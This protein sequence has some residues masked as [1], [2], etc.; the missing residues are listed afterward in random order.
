VCSGPVLQLDDTPVMCQAGRGEPSFRAYLW[1][2]VHP[3]V[4]AV[5]HRFPAGRASRLLADELAGFAGTIVGD[6][7][8]GNPAAA[9][10]LGP[11]IP[12]GACWAHVTRKLRDAED[13]APSTAT[14]FPED[15]RQLFAVDREATAARLAPAGR[16]RPR[17]ETSRPILGT[18]L[19]R[20]RRVRGQFPDAGLF[21][22]A[23]KMAR[24][25]QYVRNRWRA[26]RQFLCHFL[27][28]G[29]VPID[30]H[31]V[32]QAIRPI[33]I[34]RKNWLFAGS[35]R[36]GRAAATIY[37][38]VASCKRAEVE[39]LDYLTDVL[40]RVATHPASKIDQLLPM[41]WARH[42]APAAKELA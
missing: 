10:K 34:G 35:L 5:V 7:Y 25:M 23:G 42:F 24:A 15:I 31:E 3:Q 38:L 26:L 41:I 12:I 22:E 40:V 36:G 16:V 18:I 11:G 32:E 27:R 9:D 37:T 13:E 14:P 39:V 28:H 8:S 19:A 30:N 17:R 33:A 1:T 2:F 20:C 21:P 4:D 6:G 29:L